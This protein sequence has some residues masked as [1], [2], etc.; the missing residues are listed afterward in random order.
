MWRGAYSG[1]PIQYATKIYWSEEDGAFVAEVP[2]LDGCLAHGET[3][4]EAVSNIQEAMKLWLESAEKHN[5]PI[6]EADNDLS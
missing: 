5:D 4:E 2:A 6:P 1:T 3:Y